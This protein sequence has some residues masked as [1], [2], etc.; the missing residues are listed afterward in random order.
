MSTSDEAS[1]GVP[2]DA[3]DAPDTARTTVRRADEEDLPLLERLGQLYMHDLSEFR[4]RL[5]EA[6]GGFPFP[7]LPLFFTEPGRRAYLIEV[8]GAPAGFALTRPL[9]DGTESIG[10]FF[11]VRAVRRLGV[12]RRA[13]EDVLSRRPGRWGVAFQEENPGAARFWREVAASVAVDGWDE[14]TR[15]VAGRPELPPD[16]WIFFETGRRGASGRR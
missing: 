16:V 14:E 3:G 11:V 15:P 10:E 4:G 9:D 1:N 2:D 8:G 13:A 6:D 7:R 12:G 5:P